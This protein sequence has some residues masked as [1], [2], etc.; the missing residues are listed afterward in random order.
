M[1]NKIL[2]VY[3]FATFGG[4]ERVLLN[5]AEA[6]KHYKKNYKLYVYFYEDYGAKKAIRKYISE[7]ELDEYIEVVDK[8][9]VQEYDYIFSIDTP[10]I[11]EERG[12]E[13]KDV[14]IETHT[15]EK[16]YRKYLKEVF[17]KVKK[18]I[19]PSQVFYDQIVDEYGLKDT[20]NLFVLSNFV[21]RDIKPLTEDRLTLPAWN[22]KI[23]FYFGRIDENKNVKETVLGLKS[24]I[25]NYDANTILIIVGKI[26]PDYNFEKFIE[27]EGLLGSVVLYPPIHF[28][29]IDK[30]LQTLKTMKAVFVS[31]SRGETFS[32]S[33]AEAIS[34]DI[35]SVLSNIPA[36]KEL[37]QD[38]EKFLY[39][40][41]DHE[42]CA[43]KIDEAFKNYQ[44]YA[45]KLD[46]YKESTSSKRFIEDF[47]RLLNNEEK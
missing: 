29:K 35:P 4:V 21:L 8:L 2:V 18:V 12:I 41:G 1:K 45:K 22:K 42:E 3:Q 30:L 11:F 13:M 6:F 25:E 47:E 39:K 24:Y 14:Y 26:D 40:L 33:S 17:G 7:M 9:D 20:S 37:V 23:V 36:H 27:D 16:K 5:R 19:V 43:K 10:Q 46:T 44:S 28:E 34:I 38:D 15:A 31:S 32:L